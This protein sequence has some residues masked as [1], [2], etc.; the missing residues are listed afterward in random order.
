MTSRLTPPSRTAR[1]ATLAAIA[2]TIFTFSP[3]H[4]LPIT[5]R[6]GN[7][8]IL[9]VNTGRLRL[10]TQHVS[11][12]GNP[13]PAYS[14]LPP[15]TFRTSDPGQLIVYRGHATAGLQ[16]FPV[17]PFPAN[18]LS[19]D[20]TT[21]RLPSMPLSMSGPT[22]TLTYRSF[23]LP[24]WP[25]IPLPLL[26]WLIRSLRRSLRPRPGFCSNC[27][28]DLRATPNRCPECGT[29]IANPDGQPDDAAP[30]SRSIP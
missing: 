2:L 9:S 6:A 30:A 29:K 5:T 10:V 1:L 22:V 4:P 19:Y 13:S 28:Y 20:F 14:L 23:A 15:Y 8:Y 12:S 24:T 18:P 26:P 17:P 25:L 11:L 27:G 3:P 7:S 21:L 16:T